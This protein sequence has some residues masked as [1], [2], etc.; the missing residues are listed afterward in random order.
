MSLDGAENH[1]PAS[2]DITWHH[3]RVINQGLKTVSGAGGW[4]LTLDGQVT[5]LKFA[6]D[7]R[8]YLSLFLHLENLPK[9]RSKTVLEAQMNVILVFS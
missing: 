8:V 3:R 6:I 7:R 2:P 1:S 4:V 9:I 5:G